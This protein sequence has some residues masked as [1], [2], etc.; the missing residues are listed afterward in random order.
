MAEPKVS[1]LMPVYN[2]ERYVREAL[3]S[4][5][6]QSFGDF[7]FIIVD[8]GSTDR[9]D[10]ILEQY[11][12]PRIVRL[13]QPANLGIVAALNRGLEAAR[14]E[15]IARHDAD[16]IALP[17]RLRRQANFMDRHPEVV[18]LGSAYAVIGEDGAQ[19][20]VARP[21]LADEAI[22]WQMLF[23]NSFCHASVMVRKDVLRARALSYDPGCKHAEDYDLWSRVLAFGAGANLEAP[24]VKHRLHPRQI[25]SIAAAAQREAAEAIAARNIRSLGV[26]PA[27]EE[28]RKLRAWFHE[29]PRQL[30]GGD[31]AACRLLLEILRAF[32]KNS[33][34]DG[35][36]IPALR[37]RWIGLILGAVSASQFGDMRRSGLLSMLL[38]EDPAEV[39][40][41][42]LRR[43]RRRLKTSL[44]PARL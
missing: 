18:L 3:E 44:A 17:D 42:F 9:T 38:R 11:R 28:L 23:H 2:G 22:R 39:A 30:D 24:L 16:D 12:D 5:L 27:P 43:A 37:R 1:V 36:T 29:F 34:G 4:V 32:R 33:R 40:R 14:G 19:M 15:L 10:E 25:G 21:P 6:A 13:R 8:D 31:F 7:E 41:A 20:H 26:S 35:K